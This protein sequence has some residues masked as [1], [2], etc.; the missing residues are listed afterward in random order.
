MPN[1]I[2]FTDE[3]HAMLARID[4]RT[5]STKQDLG[6]VCNQVEKNT[7]SIQRILGALIFVSA[8]TGIALTIIGWVIK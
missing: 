3:H 6:K 5:A 8:I 1:E 4:E 7:T 2:K